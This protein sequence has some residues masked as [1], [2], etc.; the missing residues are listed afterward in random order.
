MKHLQFD[1]LEDYQSVSSKLHDIMCGYRGGMLCLDMDIY[2]VFIRLIATGD[3]LF[4]ENN[5][6]YDT[7]L[8]DDTEVYKLYQSVARDTR[9]KWGGRSPSSLESVRLNAIKEFLPHGT[10][11][12]KNGY[13]Y[14]DSIKAA[15]FC[16]NL[17]LQELFQ[18]FAGDGQAIQE[19]Y[20]FPPYM[21]TDNT[22]SYFKITASKTCREVMQKYLDLQMEKMYD[23][24]NN[25]DSVIKSIK[26]HE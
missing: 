5:Y 15:V 14:Y 26:A 22:H 8:Q 13:I 25:S 18:I 23:I 11:V 21:N 7:E 4:Y 16:E 3:L 17:N 12:Y 9:W 2:K 19:I 24:L 1:F 6:E 20:T 10:P